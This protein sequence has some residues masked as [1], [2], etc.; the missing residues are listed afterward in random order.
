MKQKIIFPTN[1]THKISRS[2]LYDVLNKRMN[3][4]TNKW[5]EDQP[6]TIWPSNF[7][8]IGGKMRGLV[9]VKFELQQ[10]VIPVLDTCKL[11]EDLLSNGQENL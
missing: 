6:K 7:F 5:T 4:R 10:E 1:S 2:Y 3:G 11:E 8:K 9:L